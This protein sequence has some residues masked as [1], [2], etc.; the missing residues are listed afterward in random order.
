MLCTVKKERQ[1]YSSIDRGRIEFADSKS[2]LE[3]I[4]EGLDFQ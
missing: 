4:A 1:T 2:S 3:S